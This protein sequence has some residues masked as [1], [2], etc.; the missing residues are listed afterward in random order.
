M[1]CA[2]FKTASPLLEVIQTLGPKGNFG[3]HLIPRTEV[4][5]GIELVARLSEAFVFAQR[6][7]LTMF[8]QNSLSKEIQELFVPRLQVLHVRKTWWLSRLLS[9]SSLGNAVLLKMSLRW[10]HGCIFHMNFAFFRIHC[11]SLPWTAH[12]AKEHLF[13]PNFALLSQMEV[14]VEPWALAFQNLSFYIFSMHWA[15]G[16]SSFT[17]PLQAPCWHMRFSLCLLGRHFS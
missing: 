5:P 6:H 4:K 2:H 8:H 16:L 17:G 10:I 14:I 11:P 15:L 12:I 7:R 9:N 13:P 1:R 3:R